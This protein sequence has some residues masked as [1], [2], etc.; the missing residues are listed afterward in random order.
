M[1]SSS[2][3]SSSS[4]PFLPSCQLSGGDGVVR[5][6]LSGSMAAADATN[7]GGCRWCATSVGTPE[8]VFDARDYLGGARELSLRGSGDG[9]YLML[10]CRTWVRAWVLACG[11]STE[12]DGMWEQ[13]KVGDSLC[14]HAVHVC[15][16]SPC[17]P[18]PPSLSL[19][20]PFCHPTLD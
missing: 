19:T 16:V 13:L 2:S 3:S 17:S 15:G 20:F 8:V 18:P 4:P 7:G 11:Q 1:S 5:C 10:S 12:Q 14:E 9:Q 6:R